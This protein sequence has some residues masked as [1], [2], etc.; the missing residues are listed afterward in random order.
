MLNCLPNEFEAAAW[1]IE[2]AAHGF[3]DASDTSFDYL[4][5]SKRSLA[6]GCSKRAAKDVS[7]VCLC[8]Q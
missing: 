1:S 5:A 8:Y 6:E 3:M 4:W 7:P 2:E